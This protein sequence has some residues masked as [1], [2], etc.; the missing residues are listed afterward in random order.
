MAANSSR[1]TI[2]KN[3]SR[4]NASSNSRSDDSSAK[5]IEVGKNDGYVNVMGNEMPEMPQFPALKAKP[6]F[7][8]G[9]VKDWTGKPLAGANIGVR[10]S[11]LAGYYSG[12]QGTTDAKGFYE[13]AVPKGSAHFYNA[14]YALEW[15]DGLAAVGLHPADGSLDS[16]TTADGVVENFVLLPYGITSRAKVQ[17][18]G[19]LPANYY[20]GSIYIH[21]GAYEASDN[22]PY[23]GYVPENSVIEISLT[24]NTGQSFVIRKVAGFQSLFRINNIPL[25]RYKISAKVNGKSLNLKQTGVFNQTFGMTPRETNGAATVL[26]APDGAKAESV[27]PQSGGWDAVSIDL[28]LQ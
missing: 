22:R 24:S 4:E 14:G 26:F 3:N 6:G 10:A 19:N 17:D 8:R 15:G 7:V 21:Y 20:G 1:Q 18:N 13:F 11:Y 23:A 28:A 27:A 9:Y 25:A 5:V 16:F 2:S 12:A